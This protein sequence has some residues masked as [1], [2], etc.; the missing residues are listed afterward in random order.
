MS[1][2]YTKQEVD[3]LLCQAIKLKI[4]LYNETTLGEIEVLV[5][6]ELLKTFSKPIPVD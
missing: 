5:K 3:E 1:K 4:P 6:H 2:I